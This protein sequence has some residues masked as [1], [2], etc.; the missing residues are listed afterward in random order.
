MTKDTDVAGKKVTVIGAAR[1]G[2]AVAELLKANGARVFVSD[3]GSGE[4]LAP[5]I[6]SLESA[7][8]EFELGQHTERALNSDL[9]VVSPGV[10]STIPIVKEAQRRGIHIVSELEIASWFC[11]APIIA[12]TGTNG[13]TT[14]TALVGR[15]LHDA[16]KKHVVGGNI[17][18]AFS[19]LV[20][21]LDGDSIAVLEVS[22]FQLEQIEHF[23]PA[24]SVILNIT[25]DHLDRYQGS[26]EQYVAAKCRVFENQG[27]DDVLIYNYD[28]KETQRAVERATA[29]KQLAFGVD[30]RFDEGAFIEEG[31]LV[32]VIDE[33]RSEI[34]ETEQIS[35]RGIHNLYNSMAATLAVQSMGVGVPSIRAT[36]R[37]FKGVE[38]RLEFVREVN[39]V[40]YVNDS[41][42]TNVDAV[43]YALQSFAEPIV[44]L[45]GG[46]DKGNDYSKLDELVRK[47]A[48]AIV[49]IGES[50]EKV[51]GAFSGVKPIEKA[52]SMEE[53]VLV[54]SELAT[55]GDVVLLS[56][57]CASFDWFENYEHRGK[58][59]KQ[60]VH[61]L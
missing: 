51:V 59:F 23:H 45:L 28:D 25:P 10:P 43:W 6:S 49:A 46:R 3:S 34:V 27:P 48:K 26:M 29:V 4:K 16:K 55:A 1:S 37:N 12:I 57:A 47:H 39:G 35:I 7:G 60:I 36:L 15:M 50:A 14:T 38:H 33:R 56:P 58:V 22:S 42:A 18:T 41:K 40:K 19:S 30:R 24:V 31:K 17:G 9:I 52:S 20:N 11:P 44:L 5:S 8:V 53:A 13:K 32:T 54:A 21:E 2:V 61:A